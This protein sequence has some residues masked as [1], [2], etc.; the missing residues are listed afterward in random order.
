METAQM[1][2]YTSPSSWPYASC[3]QINECTSG[4]LSARGTLLVPS[5]YLVG[6][7][8]HSGEGPPEGETTS[9][10]SPSLALVLPEDK[11]GP[12][13]RPRGP[14]EGELQ[15]SVPL[16][17]PRCLLWKRGVGLPPPV[18]YLAADFV[19]LRNSGD[20]GHRSARLDSSPRCPET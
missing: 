19:D 10:N 8:G 5:A 16:P 4:D 9:Q 7:P 13:E 17:Q 1:L 11:E 18:L 2:E 12:R 20:R 6:R 15:P 3:M 14:W